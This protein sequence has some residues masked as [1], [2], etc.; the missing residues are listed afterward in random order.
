MNYLTWQV[1][2]MCMVCNRET[3]TKDE[4]SRDDFL[5]K[6]TSTTYPTIATN[7]VFDAFFTLVCDCTEMRSRV[8][9]SSSRPSM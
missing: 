8:C 7:G 5:K 3:Q 1:L 4:D 6:L 2:K 9:S